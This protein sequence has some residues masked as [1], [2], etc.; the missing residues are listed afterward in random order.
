[1]IVPYIELP[2]ATL[3]TDQVTDELVVPVT[4]AANC[5]ELPALTLAG[6]GVTETLMEPEAGGLGGATGGVGEECVAEIWAQPT[7]KQTSR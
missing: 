4:V 2:P 7:S 5:W 3:L 1:V 6:F